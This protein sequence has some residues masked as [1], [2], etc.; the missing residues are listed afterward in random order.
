MAIAVT[1]PGS[2]D[3]DV[4]ETIPGPTAS[5]I[6]ASGTLILSG[7]LDIANAVAVSLSE[8]EV[9]IVIRGTRAL[10]EDT[11]FYRCLG[12]PGA[13]IMAALCAEALDKPVRIRRESR[14]SGNSRI[15]LEV[16]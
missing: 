14:E 8:T 1:T 16:L 11:W 12:S 7:L 15:T 13:S 5:E 10:Y 9:D 6:E 4:L 2:I 3:I